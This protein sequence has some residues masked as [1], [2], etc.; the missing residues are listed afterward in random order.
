MVPVCGVSGGHSVSDVFIQPR[1]AFR[2]TL[3]K[4]ATQNKKS[5]ALFRTKTP[6][7]S[8]IMRISIFRTLEFQ[9]VFVHRF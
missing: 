9:F 5:R 8:K 3:R 6:K 1:D 4:W 7:K 2:I